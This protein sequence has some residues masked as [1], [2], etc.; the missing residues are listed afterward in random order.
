MLLLN[1]IPE[2]KRLSIPGIVAKAI[3]AGKAA[4]KEGHA[5]HPAAN[6][7]FD[8]ASHGVSSSLQ[9]HQLIENALWA[10]ELTAHAGKELKNE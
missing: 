10:E 1:P 8:R 5:F 3:A 4:E 6:A 9:Y 7:W 2:E